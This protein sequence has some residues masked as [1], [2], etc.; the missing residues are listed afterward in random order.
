MLAIVP[1]T[2]HLFE[3]TTFDMLTAA[4][5]LWM[6]VKAWQATPQRWSPWIGFGVLTGVAMEIKVLASLVL[7]CCLGGIL[8]CG[9]GRPLTGAK[10]SVGTLIAVV[11]AAPN[12]VWQ[13]THGWPQ[14]VVAQNIANGGARP[15]IRRRSIPPWWLPERNPCWTGRA[16]G[17]GAGSAAASW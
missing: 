6:L 13:A 9:P 10:P 17:C 2:G 14:L 1:A 7:I 16:G 11:L 3:T 4:A 8:I 5:V 15:T 12:L